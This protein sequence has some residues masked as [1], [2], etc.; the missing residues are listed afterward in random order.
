MGHSF[1]PSVLFWPVWIFLYH[2]S[3]VCIPVSLNIFLLQHLFKIQP[4]FPLPFHKSLLS[5]EHVVEMQRRHERLC[6]SQLE[7]VPVLVWPRLRL[8]CSC[9]QSFEVYPSLGR[10]PV[11]FWTAEQNFQVVLKTI[12]LDSH[13]E[14]QDFYVWCLHFIPVLPCPQGA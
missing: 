14:F 1:I 10:F 8:W 13:S 6:A 7:P 4:V 11:I 9:K 5:Q 12:F 2:F 3:F